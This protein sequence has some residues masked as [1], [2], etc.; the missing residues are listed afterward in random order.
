MNQDELEWRAQLRPRFG[1]AV[2]LAAFAVALLPVLGQVVPGVWERMAVNAAVLMPLALFGVPLPWRALF[3]P[4]WRRIGL[5]VLAAAALYAAG[6][7]VAAPLLSLGSARGQVAALYSWRDAAPPGWMLP[8]LLWIVVGEE[9]VWRTA[10]TLPLAARLG[11]VRGVLLAGLGFAAAH[12][13]LGV[14]VLLAVA[15]GAGAY[16]SALVVRTRSAV[17]ALVSHLLWDVAVLFLWPYAPGPGF[18]TL[19]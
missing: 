8:L 15:L 13:S 7:L 3:T 9:V 12:V 2:A 6:A 5:G 14:P 10:I 1:R 18:L 16:W 11:P 4:S 17:P 19:H